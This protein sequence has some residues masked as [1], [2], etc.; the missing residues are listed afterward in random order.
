MCL[1]SVGHL[2]ECDGAV[3]VMFV[4]LVNVMFVSAPPLLSGSGAPVRFIVV[5][6]ARQQ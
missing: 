6:V 5:A 3:M 1:F 4:S 2:C